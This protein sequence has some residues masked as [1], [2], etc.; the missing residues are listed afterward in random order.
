MLS[1]QFLLFAFLLSPGSSPT[2]LVMALFVMCVA[3]LAG[4]GLIIF[5]K[6]RDRPTA[7][8]GLLVSDNQE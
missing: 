5:K 6:S 7:M 3:C 4:T 8:Y 2:F 1:S